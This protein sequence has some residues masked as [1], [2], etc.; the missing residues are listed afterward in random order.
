MSM[1]VTRALA[2]SGLLLLALVIKGCATSS[3]PS[4]Y[5]LTP[6]AA[7]TT[8]EDSAIAVGIGPFELPGYLDR[9]QI[10]TPSAGVTLTV[11]EFH[12][13]AE[14][15]ENIFVRTLAANISR[16]LG[17]D[18]VYEY[19][20][21]R[22]IKTSNHVGGNVQRFDV[23]TDGLAIL[24]V[25]W[26]IFDRNRKVVHAGKRT[27]YEAVATDTRSFAARADALSATLERFSADIAAAL[28]RLV[29]P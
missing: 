28:N 7:S 6:T 1:I 27:R 8:S 2:S 5:T 21:H 24:E 29:R 26:A 25:Q 15:L 10:V 19:P 20:Y 18:A 13:W 22:N 17:S 9:P 14:P 16:H 4:Y 23:N 11:E 3:A 12:R